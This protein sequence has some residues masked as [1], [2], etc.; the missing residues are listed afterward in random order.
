MALQENTSGDHGLM[1][2]TPNDFDP[3][4]ATFEAH[5][6]REG[7]HAANVQ[8][9]CN[10]FMMGFFLAVT[11]IILGSGPVVSPYG[12]N[13]D[14][15]PMYVAM[16][17]ILVFAAIMLGRIKYRDTRLR[18]ER[19]RLVWCVLNA[20]TRSITWD[21][22]SQL[23]IHRDEHGNVTGIQVKVAGNRVA[24]Q[25]Q[26]FYR[27]DDIVAALLTHVPNAKVEYQTKLA[28]TFWQSAV[29]FAGVA[30]LIYT[31]VGI[32]LFVFMNRFWET[33]VP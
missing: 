17:L 32:A 1:S 16:A 11:A 3:S 28:P 13:V 15:A 24:L 12:R 4:D 29:E 9:I 25:I 30:M 19:Q 21:R 5:L 27:M 14:L 8:L 23:R 7:I 26:G 6:T 20:A 22:V 31:G 2:S 33:L 18:I 10:I